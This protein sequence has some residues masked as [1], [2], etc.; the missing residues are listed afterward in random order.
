MKKFVVMSA[1]LFALFAL[2]GPSAAN[3]GSPCAEAKAGEPKLIC[4]C[5]PGGTNCRCTKVAEDGSG[6]ETW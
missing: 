5:Q 2:A 6:V 3:I 4:F 1:P